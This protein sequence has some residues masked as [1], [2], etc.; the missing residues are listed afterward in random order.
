MSDAGAGR[1]G[2]SPTQ[3]VISGLYAI[4]P[5]QSDTAELL[6]QA[7]LALQGGA[8]VLQYRNKQGSAAQRLEQA[9][10]LRG[11]TREFTV[12]LIINDDAA[13]A[14]QV[15]ADGVHL[16]GEDGSVAVARAMLGSKKMI[17]V[18]CYN[19]LSLAHQAV[20]EGA[21][22]VAFGAFFASK[23]KPSAPVVTTDL[24]RQARREISLPLVAIGGISVQNG[25]T[26][27]SAGADALAVISALFSADDVLLAA[28]QF[29]NLNN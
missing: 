20:R 11:L 27:L 28:R 26:L 13:L 10:A 23:I 4:T 25:E 3:Q 19:Q 29:T 17:G 22:Y 8:R 14:K 21:D 2:F 7:R 5:E 6:R 12:P 18:S 9:S 24:L 16:G 1:S 15:D